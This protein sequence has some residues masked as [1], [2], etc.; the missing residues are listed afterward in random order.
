MSV[1]R[2]VELIAPRH[3]GPGVPVAGA[4]EADGAEDS[5]ALV[6]P[7]VG[8]VSVVAAGLDVAFGAKRRRW[9]KSDR[10]T[11]MEPDDGLSRVNSVDTAMGTDEAVGALYARF[12]RVWSACSPRAPGGSAAVIV[13]HHLLDLS[14]D[15][16]AAELHIPA[17]TV[18]SRLSRARAALAPLLDTEE[19][20]DRA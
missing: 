17:G 18:K 8:E 13:L 2:L 1:S 5:Q 9:A 6:G 11:G 3:L 16:V 7:A 20:I 14:V 10:M 4:V 19:I 12:I 15:Q